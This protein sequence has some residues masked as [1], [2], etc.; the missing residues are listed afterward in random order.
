MFSRAGKHAFIFRF[1]RGDERYDPEER[2]A[3]LS[4]L[5]CCSLLLRARW[6]TV[7]FSHLVLQNRLS[8]VP[9]R[10]VLGLVFILAGC[11]TWRYED[12]Q[13]HICHLLRLKFSMGG[14]G[15][16]CMLRLTV[17]ICTRH[18]FTSFSKDCFCKNTQLF[19]WTLLNIKCFSF[20][21]F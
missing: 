5:R 3:G 19:W 18:W 14:W 15:G 11:M 21:F 10:S 2:D 20:S 6:E 17:L 1:C 16:D 12:N 13:L 7:C 4:E 9:H 8:G